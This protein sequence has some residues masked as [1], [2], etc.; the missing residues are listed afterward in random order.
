MNTKIRKFTVGYI[1]GLHNDVFPFIRIRGKWLTAVGFNCGDK[2]QVAVE[3]ERLVI[4][5]LTPVEGS[6][7]KDEL[8]NT[9]H[10]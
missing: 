8:E 6:E 3:Y 9:S 7:P 4:T 10:S 5:K 2:I 1:S